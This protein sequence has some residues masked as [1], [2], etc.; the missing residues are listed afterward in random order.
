MIK[1]AEININYVRIFIVIIYLVGIIGLSLDFTRELFQGL[2]PMNLLLSTAILLYFHEKWSLKFVFIAFVII[3]TSIVA[4]G[5]GTN[6]GIL[7]GSYFYGKT[8]GLKIWNVPILIGVNWFVLSYAAYLLVENIRTSIFI[9]ALIGAAFL[10]LYDFFLE[11]PAGILDM[12]N[13]QDNIIPLK[14]Y[15]TWFIFAYIF[16]VLLSWK[17]IEIANPIAVFLVL[18]QFVFFAILN[19][20]LSVW[21][22]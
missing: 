6:Y 5:L 8:L 19:V 1:R 18:V 4:E 3:I 15:Y 13:W 21:V 17:K 22:F 10:V 12:W 9:K 11:R 2:T 7:F 14:N 16:I 20:T